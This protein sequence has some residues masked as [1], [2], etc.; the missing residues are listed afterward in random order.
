MLR[1]IEKITSL[2]AAL[3]YLSLNLT[4]LTPPRKPYNTIVTVPDA[5]VAIS[6]GGA[7]HRQPCEENKGRVAVVTRHS[8]KA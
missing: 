5:E 7:L 6:T 1:D 3:K 4:P 8:A 2:P